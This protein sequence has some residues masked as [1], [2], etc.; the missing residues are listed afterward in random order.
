MKRIILVLLLLVAV[1][2]GVLLVRTFTL[3]SIQANVGALPAPTLPD[4]ALANFVSAIQIPTISYSDTSLID[5]QTFVR[6]QS[7]LKNKYPLVHA[8]LELEVVH[9]YTVLFTWAGTSSTTD[10]AVLMAHQ[11]VVPIEEETIT[12]WSVDPFAGT[13][14]DD[15][16][17]GRGTVDDKI[18]LIAILESVEKLLSEG[19]KP[20]GT[21]YLL[22][23][24]DEEIGGSGAKAVAQLFRERGIRPS[25]VLDE[26]GIVTREKVPG[27]TRNVALL[28][29]SEKGSLTL[30][31]SAEMAGG[32]AAMPEKET[33][34]SILSKALVRLNDNPF[35][36]RFS[37][38]SQ[39]FAR[40]IG[41]ELPFGQRLAFANLWLFESTV[42]SIYEQSGPGNAMI[43]TTIAPTI[44]KS[45][46]KENVV[47]TVASATLNLRLLPG[48]TLESVI[49]RLRNVMDDDRIHI[50]VKDYRPASTVTSMES[51]AYQLV[52]MTARHTFDSA[53]VS[54]FLM[55]AATDS[56]HFSGIADGIIKF[57]PMVDPIGFHG[58]D[59][60]VSLDSFSKSLWFFEQLIRN[61]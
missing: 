43:R 50:K 39:D 38:S 33:A 7:F 49:H 18:N 35:E 2:A 47:P 27:L 48:D 12:L 30:E 25:L 53:V 56:R 32:H 16:I 60:R 22:F 29:T 51:S 10:P 40:A 14:K 11:D 8:N 26:G 19:F 13:V 59:E 58:I 15:F 52:E 28:G 34:I 9:N 21:V 1:F 23:G 37:P 4:F 45:G 57:S 42:F 55:I 46:M 17:W 61:L 20:N 44:L 54:P 6:F 36:P 5:Y 31:L 24:H 41:P 3:T